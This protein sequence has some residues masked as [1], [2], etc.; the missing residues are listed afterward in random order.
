MLPV[1]KVITVIGIHGWQRLGLG[2]SRKAPIV[3]TDRLDKS[4]GKIIL[5]VSGGDQG[6]RLTPRACPFYV[7]TAQ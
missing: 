6:D 4:P 5:K 3:A 7:F 1:L 2:K